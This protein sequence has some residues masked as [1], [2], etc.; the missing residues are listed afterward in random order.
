M[1]RPS[2]AF[3]PVRAPAIA[4]AV[5]SAHSALPSPAGSAGSPPS[6]AS[7]SAPS[8]SIWTEGTMLSSVEPPSSVSVDVPVV[9]SP[10]PP[11]DWG[12]QAVR[13]RV[14]AR[15]SAAPPLARRAVR[16]MPTSV[17]LIPAEGPR[18][19][20]P[21][22]GA[23]NPQEVAPSAFLGDANVGGSDFLGRSE[24]LPTR[25]ARVSFRS[26]DGTDV[27]F[28]GPGL[29]SDDAPRV[30]SPARPLVRPRT[31]RALPVRPRHPR[32]QPP[33]DARA[34]GPDDG[35]DAVRRAGG[36]GPARAGH[37]GRGRGAR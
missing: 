5:P 26:V 36:R 13:T 4:I 33:A 34:P 10:P 25:N 18:G 2:A 9:S 1:L 28:P 27:P 35:G 21:G 31:D 15:S 14:A 7:T 12:P 24:L 29:P 8:M 30:P 19:V 23:T 3:G 17:V 20:P 11:W 16:C 22:S 6:V 32:R 37:V